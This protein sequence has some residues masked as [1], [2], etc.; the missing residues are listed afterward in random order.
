MG[1]SP[2][3]SDFEEDLLLVAWGV[4]WVGGW[5]RGWGLTVPTHA[6]AHIVVGCWHLASASLCHENHGTTR[7]FN[8]STFQLFSLFYL[9]HSLAPPYLPGHSPAFTTSSVPQNTKQEVGGRHHV[10]RRRGDPRLCA[11]V[12]A[13]A[14][15]FLERFASFAPHPHRAPGRLLHCYNKKRCHLQGGLRH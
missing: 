11:Y 12:C 1:S 6:Y 8:S 7:H 3:L 15:M 10:D 2:F 13:R 4:G 9:Q 5:M 14:R